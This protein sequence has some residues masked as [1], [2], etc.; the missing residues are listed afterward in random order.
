MYE[1]DFPRIRG[2]D[3]ITL[4]NAIAAGLGPAIAEVQ[5]PLKI[6]DPDKAIGLAWNRADTDHDDVINWTEFG[7]FA[8]E[9]HTISELNLMN[10]D[11][12]VAFMEIDI[13]RDGRISKEEIESFLRMQCLYAD[14]RLAW[15]MADIDRDGFITWQEFGV[16]STG[17]KA[18]QPLGTSE[19]PRVFKAIDQNSDGFLELDDVRRYLVK[20]V[21]TAVDDISVSRAWEAGDNDRDGKINFNEFFHFASVLKQYTGVDLWALELRRVF[22]QI[23]T[24]RDGHL[25]EQE[26]Y[27]YLAKRGMCVKPAQLK[28]AWKL[29]DRDG[30]SCIDWEEFG[31]FAANVH[32]GIDLGA[33]ELRRVFLEI[34]TDFDHVLRDTE[35]WSYLEARGLLASKS[36][37]EQIWRTADTD[38]D[39]RIGW[40]EFSVFAEAARSTG[41][42]LM[43]SE[44]RHVFREID[45]DGDGTLVVDEVAG[46]LSQ[47]DLTVEPELLQALWRRSAAPNG[48]IEWLSFGRLCSDLR[49]EAGVDL[50]NRQHRLVFLEM[51]VDRDGRVSRSELE[52]FLRMRGLYADLRAA[53]RA[54][55]AGREGSISWRQFGAF[56]NRLRAGEPLGT[57]ELPRVFKAIDIDS[58]GALERD[59]IEKF[60]CEKFGVEVADDEMNR[61]WEAGDTDGDGRINFNEFFHFASVLK[62]YTGVD[63]WALELRRVFD[64]IDTDRDGHLGEQEVYRYLA[65]RGMCVKPAQLKAAWKLADRDGDSCIDWEEFG[66]FAANVHVG[67]DLGASELRR[68][69][70]EIDTDFDHVLRDTEVWSY[71][72]ARGLLASKSQLEQIWR[73]AD[74]D[75]DGRI[76]W[77]E[78]SVFAE[79]AR[80]TGLNLM[81]SEL[82][83][84]FREIDA[85]GDGCLA[86]EEVKSYLQSCGT[87]VSATMINHSWGLA[88]HDKDGLID[89]TEFGFFVRDLKRNSKVDVMGEDLRRVFA[90]VDVNRDLSI[91]KAELESFL[92]MRGLYTDLRSAWMAADADKD[93]SISWRE[94]G[95]LARELKEGA[96]LGTSELPRVFKAIDKDSDGSLQREEIERFLLEKLKMAAVKINPNHLAQAWAAGDTDGDGKINFN[97]F[98]HFASVLKQYTGVDLWALELRRVFDQ[99]D[100][101]RDGHLGEQ[102]VYR[103]LA[104]RGMC[105]KPAQLKAA[106]KLADRDGDSC[107][108]W[109]EFGLFAANV[110]VGID[111]GASELRRVFLEIDSDCDGTLS[112]SEVWSYLEARGLLASNSQLEQVWLTADTD[113]NGRIGWEEFSV[114]AESMRSTGLNLMEGELRH[115]FLEI[116]S[117]GDGCLHKAEVREFLL[118]Q[119]LLYPDPPSPPSGSLMAAS[120]VHVR[121]SE[122]AGYKP[123]ASLQGIS[124]SAT[125][126]VGIKSNCSGSSLCILC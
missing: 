116:D 20:E 80:S 35:V 54:A 111:L 102:E 103:Y 62:Q 113:G 65:K 122:R 92:R 88:D 123:S 99:I 22:D 8:R 49:R 39:G 75:G 3:E 112:S 4:K 42:N 56:A 104:K 108:D 14:L 33:S 118:R 51:D 25:G 93:G 100:T 2:R 34:D 45:A 7:I 70:L 125:D 98:F 52:G 59:E 86:L 32:V 76:G 19:L 41:L 31:L 60:L 5:T 40:E 106:W 81:E 58:D 94:F 69:F 120:S 10:K 96:P 48:G 13:N 107:I 24:D 21:K 105:V 23:D 84:V 36:Q 37:L 77:E 121:L 9:L 114:F 50:F 74:T 110:H 55:G 79:A 63:L 16:F 26:V 18:G 72:E 28:A 67:I 53:W 124:V 101:D 44:L 68:V 1:L 89:W 6:S 43:E 46:Y 66:L 64:Q 30:D 73:T 61:A 15:N 115:V 29:A 95:I 97:E 71:L 82:R 57:S 27:R 38:G 12:R 90:E 11:L 83:H 47:R 91:T 117:D 109:E 17:L 85:D 126:R 87:S 78:F 119:H